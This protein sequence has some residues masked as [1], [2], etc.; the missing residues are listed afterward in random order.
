MKK[1][2]SEH[3]TPSSRPSSKG[4]RPAIAIFIF[5]I[6]IANIFCHAQQTLNALFIGNSYTEVNNLPEMVSQI[7]L[8]TGNSLNYQS[9]TPGGCTFS[10]HC[11]NR[12]MELIRQGGW[13]IVVL[14]EQSQYPSFPQYQVENEVFPYAQ[15]LVDS[16]YRHSPCAE[17][18]FYMT[19]GRKNGDAGNA[20]IFPVLG[21]Y[22]GMD[23]MLCLRYTYMAET[24]DASLCPVGRVWRY[25]RT[26]HPDIELYQSDGSHPSLAGTYAAACAFYTVFFHRDPTEITYRSTLSD[27]VASAIRNAVDSIVYQHLGQW[28]RPQPVASFESHV[29][30]GDPM[31]VILNSTSLHADSLQWLFDNDETVCTTNPTLTHTFTDTGT[32]LITLIALRHCLT[33]TASASVHI[34][35]DTTSTPPDPVAVPTTDAC[36]DFGVFPNPTDGIVNITLPQNNQVERLVVTDLY[37]RQKEALQVRAANGPTVLSLSGYESGIYLLHIVTATGIVVRK[38]VVR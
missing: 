11:T 23:S 37:G 27:D 20:P 1:S 17:P 36:L 26:K 15:R 28:R 9:N 31:S 19:W 21:T 35:G 4:N 10:Q 32:H 12:S 38:L 30:D 6:L 24:N 25:L 3:K 7:A 22:E 5:F 33:D 14:Q 8:S 18:V 2:Y 29:D 16:I 34:V 13:D